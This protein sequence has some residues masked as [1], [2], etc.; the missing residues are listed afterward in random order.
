M[1]G[2]ATGQALDLVFLHELPAQRL[3]I[4]RRF[5]SH[6]KH[7]LARAHVL[8]RMA[9]AV[10]A[11]FH[12]E[13]GLLPGE[14]HLVHG[15]VAGF[16]ADAL[17]DV[18]AVIEIG[19][20]GQI[21]HARPGDGAV[22]AETFAHR[23]E[24]GAGVPDLRMT[25]H[26]GLGRGDVGEGRSLDRGVAIAAVNPDVADM[27]GVAEGHGLLAGDTGLG[28]PGGAAPGAEK[29]QQKTEDEHRPE[30]AYLRERVRAAMKNLGHT[31]RSATSG[32]RDGRPAVPYS[33]LL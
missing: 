7:F 6:P 33:K 30:D 14:R 28:R 11:P 2:G 27:M 21:M 24:R 18:D 23:L 32:V 4:D 10:E 26:A 25:I 31:G 13:R 5:V 17:I 20:I 9:V 3:L 12:L 1:T 22:R 8:L 16:A 29:P 19:E 15:A